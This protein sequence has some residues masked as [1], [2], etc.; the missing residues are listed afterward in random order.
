MGWVTAN[1][2]LNKFGDH[3][4]KDTKFHATW[5]GDTDKG[6][7]IDELKARCRFCLIV[8]V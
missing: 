5:G 6:G 8:K 4:T 2:L 3:V 1:Y 7:N